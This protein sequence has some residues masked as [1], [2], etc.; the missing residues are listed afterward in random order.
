MDARLGNTSRYLEALNMT[1]IVLALALLP[2]RFALARIAAGICCRRSGP[3][4]VDRRDSR[5]N[6]DRRAVSVKNTG[7]GMANL[8]FGT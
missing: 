4:A 7:M 3:D 8:E 5:R 1:T 2:A 6:R